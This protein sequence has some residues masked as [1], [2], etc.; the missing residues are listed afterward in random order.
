MSPEQRHKYMQSI[1]EAG[2]KRVREIPEPVGQKFPV[3]SFV[4]IA[5][6]HNKGQSEQFAKVQYT[7]AHAYEGD[8]V[9]NYSLLVR[10]AHNSWSSGAWYFESQLSPV[11]NPEV[12]KQLKQ[13]I[14]ILEGKK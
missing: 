9:T 14:E 13:E 10:Y 2:L 1:Y 6:K 12:V 11:D 4:R 5:D 8:D 3:G 7:Y